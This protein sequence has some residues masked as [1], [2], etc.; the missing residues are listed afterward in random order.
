[1]IYCPDCEAAN[2][3]DAET[4]GQCGKW[5]SPTPQPETPA[6]RKQ[7]TQDKKYR[8]KRA[9]MTAA[10]EAVADQVKRDV[11]E[12]NRQAEL[13]RY[14][15]LKIPTGWQ[16]I[17]VGMYLGVGFIIAPLV[18]AIAWFSLMVILAATVGATT[19]IIDAIAN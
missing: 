4:C 12:S 13:S 11:A 1:M 19:E 18:I 10:V 3:D 8:E 6:A 16:M 17:G 14:V 5:L 7:R 9:A 2:H 15:T